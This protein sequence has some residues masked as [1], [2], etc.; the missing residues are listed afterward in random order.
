MSAV[1]SRIMLAD[2]YALQ[3][4]AAGTHM[5]AAHHPIVDRRTQWMVLSAPVNNP[6]SGEGV[7]G[8]FQRRSHGRT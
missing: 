3:N 5:H 6:T 7:D 1:G 8:T 2:R 4:D